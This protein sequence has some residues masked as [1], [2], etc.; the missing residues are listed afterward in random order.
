MKKMQSERATGVFMNNAEGILYLDVQKTQDVIQG[1][2][3]GICRKIEDE[4]QISSLI[5][6]R[7]KISK[8][9]RKTNY[10]QSQKSK[11]ESKLKA[12][13]I[14]PDEDLS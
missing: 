14:K 9:I 11:L 2:P 12:I 3:D 6:C 4:I 13:F 10:F 7:K 1:P 5:K 8:Q